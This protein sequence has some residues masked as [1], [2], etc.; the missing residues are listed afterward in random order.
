VA[1][2]LPLDSFS[3]DAAGVLLKM[4]GKPSFPLPMITTLVFED[5]ASLSVASMPR[6]R[7]YESEIP[8]L[9]SCWNA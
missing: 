4:M 9:T 1:A 8:S 2:A 6:H 3:T 7:K 5:C